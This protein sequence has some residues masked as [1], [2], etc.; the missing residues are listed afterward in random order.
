M[1]N[2][3]FVWRILAI[4]VIGI[5]GLWLGYGLTAYQANA[6]GVVTRDEAPFNYA[7]D[8][9]LIY[10]D[11]ATKRE[12]VIFE[13]TIR[14]RGDR[15]A[16]AMP[17]PG[18]VQLAAAGP[19]IFLR[20]S[21]YLAPT[22]IETKLRWKLAF[23]SWEWLK[24]KP[25]VKPSELPKPQPGQVVVARRVVEAG[26]ET[27]PRGTQEEVEKAL[28]RA[29]SRDPDEIPFD[30]TKPP[31]PDK[32]LRLSEPFLA[33]AK[34]YFAQK[35]T[36]VVV[37]ARTDVPDVSLGYDEQ[38][39]IQPFA[40]SFT[41]DQPVVPLVCPAPIPALTDGPQYRNFKVFIVADE[42]KE[43][44]ADGA[45][46]FDPAA[47]PFA[48]RIPAADWMKRV[49]APTQP[50]FQ[51]TG[52]TFLTTFFHTERDQRLFQTNPVIVPATTQ[53]TIRPPANIVVRE[54]PAI[55]PGEALLLILGGGVIYW[56]QRQR[57]RR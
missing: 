5:G 43:V 23:W 2:L 11:P 42:R 22:I 4:V 37:T 41:T 48:D 55:I 19:Q 34:P 45:V 18:E 47:A 29:V 26:I 31:K 50:E 49:L 21:E 12:T 6:A 35:A 38:A 24:P 27:F 15:F 13:P 8:R 44:R 20:L 51:P 1:S 17:F 25:V 52:D 57:E 33:W 40:V 9:L 54:Q 39:S 3:S 56:R 32:P 46:L 30:P 16:W 53:A 14:F 36:W 28:Q 7:E 10:Y